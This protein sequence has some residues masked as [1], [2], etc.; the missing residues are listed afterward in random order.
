MKKTVGWMLGATALAGMAL[1]F[2]QG[3][4]T[5]ATMIESWFI[6]AESIGDPVAVDKGF[7]KDAGLDVT[8]VA[9][10]PGLSPIDRVMA[11]SKA[12]KLVF[13]IDY[14]YNLL[15]ARQKQK[16][17]LVMLSADFQGS[18]MHILSWKPI[19]KPAE[20]TGQFAT[21]IGYD[22]P[23]KAVVGKNWE[24]QLQVVNQQGDPATLGGWLAKQ[25]NFA[26]AMVYNE[27]M[28][29]EK[30]AKDKYY[31][32][33]YKDFGVDWP[34]NVLFTTEDVLKKYPNEVK[35]FVQAR[36][37]GFRFA[38]DNPEEAG[39]ILGKYNPNLDIPFELKGLEQIAKIMT[40]DKDLGYVNVAKIQKMATQLKAAGILDSSSLVGFLKTTPS[41]VK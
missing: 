26:S 13:G 40:S 9:G 34:E 30:Q 17:P 12:G 5:K 16:L 33:S 3:N 29:A 41:G 11:E 22:K 4:L 20:I 10:G 23:I 32:Y 1:V 6:H 8:V 24:K 19:S 2:A 18:A 25:Y 28:V 31:V 27:V 38:I 14:P 37:K 35:K 36:Y 21:W 39:K 7:Y 15:E